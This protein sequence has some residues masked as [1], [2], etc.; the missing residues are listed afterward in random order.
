MKR[1]VAVAKLSLSARARARAKVSVLRVVCCHTT[2][3]SGHCSAALGSWLQVASEPHAAAS[4][5]HHRLSL[6]SS[7]MSHETAR[8]CYATHPYTWMSSPA[9]AH[10]TR[11]AIEGKGLWTSHFVDGR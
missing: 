1:K 4:A 8:V 10:G 3:R 11:L 2:G 6:L 9:T 7:H 5:A